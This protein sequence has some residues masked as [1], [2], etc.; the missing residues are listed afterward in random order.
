MLSIDEA[1]HGNLARAGELRAGEDSIWTWE[2]MT[3]QERLISDH[4]LTSVTVTYEPT[5]PLLLEIVQADGGTLYRD[6]AVHEGDISHS[7]PI[8]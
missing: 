6:P 1:K 2:A 3:G 7:T 4:E 8:V 5:G